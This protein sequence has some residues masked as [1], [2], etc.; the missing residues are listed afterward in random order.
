MC[1]AHDCSFV[2]LKS[3][4]SHSQ[5]A[6]LKSERFSCRSFF[7]FDSLIFQTRSSLIFIE[8]NLSHWFPA[9]I[10]QSNDDNFFKE[11]LT[12]KDDF[13]WRWKIFLFI[14]PSPLESISSIIIIISWKRRKRKR[15][16]EKM[17]KKKKSFFDII[18]FV[19]HWKRQQ[20]KSNLIWKPEMKTP[21][22]S[23]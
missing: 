10:A 20:K 19:R 12:E 21:V 5:T 14:L 6:N 11:A 4:H 18:R 3:F 8:W 9:S 22:I 15:G 7:S 17:E 1:H 2:K 13:W 16:K 23:A